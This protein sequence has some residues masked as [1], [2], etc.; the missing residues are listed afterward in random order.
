M[1][2]LNEEKEIVPGIKIG[3]SNPLVVLAGPCVIEGDEMLDDIASY[4]KNAASEAGVS[5]FFK[6]SFDK[7]NR[8][9]H[10]SFR[11]PGIDK[12]LEA[13]QKIKDKHNLPIV[14]DIHLP[15]QAA[16]AAQVADILQIPAFLCRQSD[17]LEAAAATGKW[18]NIKKGQFIAPQDVG[19]VTQKIREQGNSKVS[20]CER[21]F[22]FGYNNLV[23]DMRAL[24][25]MRKAGEHVILDATHATQL[26]GGGVVSGGQREMALPLARAAAA[27]G[28]DGLFTEVHPNP[29]QAKSDATNQM[30]LKDWAKFIKDI[31]KIDRLV[32]GL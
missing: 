1:I 27:V 2:L 13:L 18:V 30:Y 14:T 15:Q 31:A 5:L 28:I 21:G 8:S 10:T 11:G 29:P 19:A 7:A 25:Q 22:T 12:G 17:L 6:S 26:P 23:V 4:V 20:I 24:E 32:K 3:G 16:I 9:S